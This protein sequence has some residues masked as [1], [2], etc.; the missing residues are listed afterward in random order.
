MRTPLALLLLAA[1]AFAAPRAYKPKPSVAFA[2]SFDEAVK[3]ARALNAPIIV[4][5]HG[6]Y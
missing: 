3:E 5:R 6:F 1:V 2:P 4:H